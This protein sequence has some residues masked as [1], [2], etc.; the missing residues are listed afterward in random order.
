[1]VPTHNP[2][3]VTLPYR[4][5]EWFFPGKVSW[6][7]ITK[8][9]TTG[10]WPTNTFPGSPSNEVQ[11]RQ[12]INAPGTCNQEFS[13]LLNNELQASDYLVS[14]ESL[15]FKRQHLKTDK[16]KKVTCRKHRLWRN[17]NINKSKTYVLRIRSH[18]GNKNKML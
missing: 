17:Q 5:K 12:T 18:P 3:N 13:F 2:Y 8:N 15:L 16:R 9:P 11:N 4:H 7:K 10:I 14:T 1:M 6:K